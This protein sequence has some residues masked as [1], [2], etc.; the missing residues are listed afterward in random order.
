MRTVS[1]C[2]KKVDPYVV[3]DRSRHG[4]DV[5]CHHAL[6]AAVGVK[7]ESD[8]HPGEDGTLPLVLLKQH[9]HFYHFEAWRALSKKE[10]INSIEPCGVHPRM[11]AGLPSF[12]RGAM[13][14][15]GDGRHLVAL[16][17]PHSPEVAS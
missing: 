6:A 12:D 17:F 10:L 11:Q 3:L 9:F 13:G 1:K 8:H 15:G 5:L 2:P 7:H 4:H 14:P 16:S